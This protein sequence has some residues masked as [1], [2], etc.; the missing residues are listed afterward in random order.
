[1][2]YS[3]KIDRLGTPPAA[4][5]GTALDGSASLGPSMPGESE[6]QADRIAALLEESTQPFMGLDPE[7]RLKS[8]N[9]AMAKLLGRS[10]SDLLGQPFSEWTAPCQ[11]GIVLESLQR[12]LGTRSAQLFEITLVRSD[13]REVPVEVALEPDGEPGHSGYFAFV[14]DLT[15]HKLVE[16]ALRESE[17]RFRRLYDEAPVGYHE[18]DTEGRIV[19]INKTECDMLGYALDELIGRSVFE[20]IAEESREVARKAF[21]EKVAGR[22]PLRPFERTIMTRDGRALILAFEERHKHDQKGNVNGLRTTVRD[23]TDKKRAEAALLISE[24]RARALF[25]GMEEAVFVHDVEGRILDA[26]PAA[27]RLLGY[28]REE[29]LAMTTQQID[30]PDFAAGYAG[31][32]AK[33]FDVGHLAIEGKH[34]TKDGRTLPVEINT[35]TIQLDDQKAVLAVIR[36]ISERRALED[37]RQALA[38]AREANALEIASKNAALTLSEARYRQLTEGCLDGVVAADRGGFV[39]LFNPAAGRIFGYREDE[40]LGGHLALLMPEAFKGFQETADGPSP[41]VGRTVEVV[42]RRKGGADF[43]I[44]LS[45]SAVKVGGETQYVASLRDQTERQRMRAVLAQS[46]KLA[47]IGLLSAGVAHEIN[48]P[49]A[50]VGNNLAVLERDLAGVRDMIAGYERLRTFAPAELLAEV[51]TL[52]EAVDWPY[53]RENLPRMLS[54]TREG[55]QRVA[56]I[57]SNLRSL[58][59]TAPTKME[60]VAVADLLDNAL[61]MLRGRLRRHHIEVQVDLEDSPR[62]VCVATQISQVFLNLLVNATQAVESAGRQAGGTIRVHAVRVGPMLVVSVTDDGVGIPVEDVS[63][64]FDPFFTTKSVGEGTGL[65]LAI[66]HGI[67][68][69]HGGRIEVESLPGTGTSF[70]VVLPIQPTSTQNAIA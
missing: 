52:V 46:E 44:E 35:S 58:A 24:R 31:R 5:P 48:N 16:C 56:N 30:A 41:L 8:V 59:R 19:S 29:L 53:V 67:V 3:Q 60:D 11:G 2:D 63:R 28:S 57:V 32:L 39:T 13:G 68:S 54:R 4:G 6:G 1:M 45:L 65:G 69:G 34:R 14:H 23:V 42:G 20:V 37:A 27:S 50:Y 12:V 26:N 70:R 61:E 18:V 43:P 38:S 49:L 17:E 7:G 25:Q 64:L 22:L 40:I 33:Q 47:S 66:C 36:D 21:P 62:L 15:D 9:Q 55:V 10:A 51:D